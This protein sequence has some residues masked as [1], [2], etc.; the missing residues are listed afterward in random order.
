MR[1]DQPALQLI[2]NVVMTTMAT[3]LALICHLLKQ[4]NLRLTAELDRR[5]ELGATLP[6]ATAPEKVGTSC[7]LLVNAVPPLYQDIR[8][9]VKRRSQD[10]N[11]IV[12]AK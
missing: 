5:N 3:S 9:Y 6:I 4:D 12:S 2:L 10:W 7:D 8:E 11:G 1:L